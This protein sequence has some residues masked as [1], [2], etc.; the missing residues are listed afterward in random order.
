MILLLIYVLGIALC[1][2]IL[3]ALDYLSATSPHGEADGLRLIVF[4]LFWPILVCMTIGATIGWLI[5]KDD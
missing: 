3:G 4:S 1:A 5:K 2:I